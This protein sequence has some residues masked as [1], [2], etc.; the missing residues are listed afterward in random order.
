[1]CEDSL[2]LLFVSPHALPTL[3]KRTSSRAHD[4]L[5]TPP[6]PPSLCTNDIC[7]HTIAGSSPDERIY[8]LIKQGSPLRKLSFSNFVFKQKKIN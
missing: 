2:L 3:G 1:M 4:V 6:P 7:R 8:I 5:R